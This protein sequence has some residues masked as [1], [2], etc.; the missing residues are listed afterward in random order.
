[1]ISPKMLDDLEELCR[2]LRQSDERFGGIRC[3]FWKRLHAN[4]SREMNKELA[5]QA[6]CWKELFKGKEQLQTLREVHRHQDDFQNTVILIRNLTGAQ[7][8]S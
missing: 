7:I 3:I 2:K 1:M 8:S 4:P 5:F 6:D